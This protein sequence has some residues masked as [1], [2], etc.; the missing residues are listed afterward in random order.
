MQRKELITVSGTVMYWITE[1]MDPSKDTIFFLHGLTADHTMFEAQVD[2]FGKAYNV[3]TWD[4]PAHGRSRPFAA[5]D[6]NESSE[7]IRNI[8]DEYGTDKAVFV[9]QSLGGY[10]AQS[11]IKRYPERVKAFVSIGSTPYG[12]DYYSKTDIWLVEQVEWM[13]HLYPLQW[14]K[15]AMAKQVSTTQRTYDNMMQMLEPYGKEE[16]CHLMRLGYAGF[17]KDNCDL[18]IPCPV[19]LLVGEYDKTG[20]VMQYNREW[21]KKTG[22][23]LIII[24]DAAHNANVDKPD[25]VNEAIESFLNG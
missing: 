1:P 21:T 16:L 19:L 25:V 14:M 6:F 8:L 17:L 3:I 22:Y 9:G 15:K 20:K 13:A 5:F 18:E 23:P 10:F 12:H 4:A 2:Y 7:Y 11:F 24:K